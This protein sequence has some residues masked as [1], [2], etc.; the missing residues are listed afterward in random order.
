MNFSLKFH[1]IRS[2]DCIWARLESEGG[3]GKAIDLAQYLS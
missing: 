1:L 2:K 3:Y